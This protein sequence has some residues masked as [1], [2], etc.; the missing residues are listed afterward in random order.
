MVTTKTKIA[1]I[2][3]TLLCVFSFA[4]PSLTSAAE[5]GGLVPCNGV[6]SGTDTRGTPDKECTF[7]ELI[8]LFNLII[9]FLLFKLAAPLAVLAFVYAGFLYITAAGD[10]GKIAKAHDIFKN[11][12]IGLILAFGAFLIVTAILKG[13]DTDSDFYKILQP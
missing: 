1:G 2:F 10:T 6:K 8:A 13:L 11:V 7:T 4:T 5:S 3:F 9:N 12:L